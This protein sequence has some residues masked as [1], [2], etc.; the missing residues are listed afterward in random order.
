[1]CVCVCVCLCLC[2]RPVY[3]KECHYIARLVGIPPGSNYVPALL[4]FSCG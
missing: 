1:V 4:V 3:D 2:A